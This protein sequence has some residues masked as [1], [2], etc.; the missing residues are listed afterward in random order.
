LKAFYSTPR[1][2]REN[3]PAKGNE[4]V[5]FR[6]LSAWSTAEPAPASL[7]DDDTCL[8]ALLDAILVDP[9]VVGARVLPDRQE[10]APAARMILTMKARWHSLYLPTGILA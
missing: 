3:N 6:Q 2:P 1:G 9:V 10:N 5:A 7:A 8:P 4:I